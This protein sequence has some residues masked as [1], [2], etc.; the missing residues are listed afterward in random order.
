MRKIEDIRQKIISREIKVG[1]ALSG[2]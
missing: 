2:N 1:D